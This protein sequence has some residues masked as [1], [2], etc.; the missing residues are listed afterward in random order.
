MAFLGAATTHLRSMSNVSLGN[1]RAPPYRPPIPPPRL[2][3]PPLNA[4]VP[5]T[6]Y[7]R[8]VLDYLSDLFSND[9]YGP[10][11]TIR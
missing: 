7:F 4:K 5:S 1:N 2:P 3:T 9:F 10:T 11:I 8:T 6:S